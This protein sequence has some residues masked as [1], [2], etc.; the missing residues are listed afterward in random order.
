MVLLF[1]LYLV[2]VDL[3]LNMRWYKYDYEMQVEEMYEVH[4]EDEHEEQNEG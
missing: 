4:Y 3:S 2:F 1:L